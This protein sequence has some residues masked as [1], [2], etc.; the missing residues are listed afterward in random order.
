MIVSRSHRILDRRQR[1]VV[2]VDAA[3][4]NQLRDEL[5]D[6]RIDDGDRRRAGLGH[7]QRVAEAGDRDRE[8][9]ALALELAVGVDEL[10]GHRVERHA[11]LLELARTRRSHARTEPAR[12]EPA[13]RLDQVL[14]RAAHAAHE[15]RD[16]RQRRDEREHAG[17]RDQQQ[18]P[19]RVPSGRS[20]V[21]RPGAR[22]GAPAV[23]RRGHWRAPAVR[24]DCLQARTARLPRAG[25]PGP[26]RRPGRRRGACSRG[27]RSRARSPAGR[28]RRTRRPPGCEPRPRRARSRRG[29]PPLR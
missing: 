10:I 1:A 2:V 29:A 18:R 25:A 16:Q 24:P 20:S 4:D 13:R 6:P 11:E 23:V 3:A 22:A 7:D 5:S 26:R 28:R 27:P 14:E 21:P 9:L 12:H 19:P 17:D 15:R 8:R